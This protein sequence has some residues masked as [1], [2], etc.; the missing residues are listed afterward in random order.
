[1][2]DH[3][4]K[5][6]LFE[7]A[8][9]HEPLGGKHEP[10]Q[11]TSPLAAYGRPRRPVGLLIDPCNQGVFNQAESC[12]PSPA[13]AQH[14][15]ESMVKGVQQQRAAEE[16]ARIARRPHEIIDHTTKTFPIPGMQPAADLAHL[17]YYASDKD[18][19]GAW[20]AL[21]LAPGPWKAAK[22][23]AKNTWFLPRM[24]ARFFGPPAPTIIGFKGAALVERVE[25]SL[26]FPRSENYARIHAAEQALYRQISGSEKF[27]AAANTRFAEDAWDLAQEAGMKWRVVNPLTDQVE[28]LRSFVDYRRV[29]MEGVEAGKEIEVVVVGDTKTVVR[30]SFD[31]SEHPGVRDA[32][33]FTEYF[34][35]EQL[36]R[37]QKVRAEL[38][39][40]TPVEMASKLSQLVSGD[41]KAVGNLTPSAVLDEAKEVAHALNAITKTVSVPVRR[42]DGTLVDTINYFLHYQPD[43]KIIAVVSDSHVP[44]F[45]H[46]FEPEYLLA[47]KRDQIGSDLVHQYMVRAGWIRE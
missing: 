10:P 12:K 7:V 46:T 47:A 43:G 39:H 26:L 25:L 11:L 16:Q 5:P 18:P 1:M 20:N 34:T 19:E 6:E 32:K 38:A 14:T 2:T 45:V 35:S 23:G 29:G 28:T 30:M 33:A 15:L 37:L 41:S 44:S 17:G 42:A 13:F 27:S 8:S 36:V 24:I 22:V 40:L 9:L 21:S 3:A 31:L 4:V